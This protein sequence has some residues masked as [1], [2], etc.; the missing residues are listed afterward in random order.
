LRLKAQESAE[1]RSASS[2]LLPSVVGIF[3][4]ILVL[5]I[6]NLGEI[7][8]ATKGLSE[9]GGSSGMTAFITGLNKWLFDGA[10]IPVRIG[11]WY[12]TAT[13][14]IPDTINEFPFFTFT[15]AD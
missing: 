2:I 13:R 4:V 15:Y 11:D 7:K 12:W 10:T 8:L 6:G 9:L 3:G 1:G 5:I 14:V